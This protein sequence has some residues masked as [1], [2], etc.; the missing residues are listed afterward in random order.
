MAQGGSGA[1]VMTYVGLSA[2]LPGGQNVLGPVTTTANL[3]V[4]ARLMLSLVTG[5][6]T[7]AIPAGSTSYALIL[8][9]GLSASVL[10]RTNLNATDGGLPISSSQSQLP[11]F[12]ADVLPG[13]TQLIINCSADIPGFT[14]CDFI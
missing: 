12:K 10:L 2:G 13:M 3:T 6:N 4:G 5:D 11:W 8:P 1:G 7:V 14:E 9:E